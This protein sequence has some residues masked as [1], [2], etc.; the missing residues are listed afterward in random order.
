M[1]ED[2][3]IET[4][5]KEAP[6]RTTSTLFANLPVRNQ[7]SYSPLLCLL[8][9]KMNLPSSSPCSHSPMT[10]P[11]IIARRT[12]GARSRSVQDSLRISATKLGQNLRSSKT[13]FHKC[14]S[15]LLAIGISFSSATGGWSGFREMVRSVTSFVVFGVM[16]VDGIPISTGRVVWIL[17]VTGQGDVL[18]I[19]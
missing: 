18:H 5:L 14:C 1:I 17:D 12:E 7:H 10:T 3:R 16:S 8:L 2:S 15:H 9:W 19:R 6:L 4:P 11:M 13:D